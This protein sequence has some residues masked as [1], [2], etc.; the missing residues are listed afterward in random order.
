MAQRNEQ[1][2]EVEIGD[3]IQSMSMIAA[4]I[5]EAPKDMM[6]ILEDVTREVRFCS[7]IYEL[8]N[9]LLGRVNSLSE[10]RSNPQ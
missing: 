4:W 5:V 9:L 10:L 8:S 7:Y 3:I 2:L 1:S 6:S